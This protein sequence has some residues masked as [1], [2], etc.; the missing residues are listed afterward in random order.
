MVCLLAFSISETGLS[1]GGD[2]DQ[3]V[4]AWE[5]DGPDSDP[6]RYVVETGDTILYVNGQELAAEQVLELLQSFA[7]AK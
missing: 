4:V 2:G 7:P 5:L 3:Q 1:A 6:V